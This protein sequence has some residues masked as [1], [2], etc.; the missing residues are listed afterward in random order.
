MRSTLPVNGLTAAFLTTVV[1]LGLAPEASA[2]PRF[3]AFGDGSVW[4]TDVRSAPLNP[5]SAALVTN[6]VGQ[7]AENYG[8]AAFNV[9][10]YGTSIYTVPA[11]QAVVDVAW[12]D[13]QR[14][15]RAPAGLLGEGGQ[16]TAVPIP[17]DAVPAAG[18]DGQLTV[19]SPS[20][21]TLWE[22]WKAKRVNGQWQA[23]WGGRL[24]DVSTSGGY[25]S[26]WWGASASGL[27]VSG[28]SVL[29]QDAQAG[30]VDH[31]LSLQLPEVQEKS[32]YSWP[33]QRS[34][35]DDLSAD[36][37]PEGLRF[38]LDPTVNVE[39]LPLTP[40]AKMVARSAQTYGFIVTDRAGAVAVV[41]ESPSA[42]IAATGVNP[43]TALMRG[44]KS[45][46][47]FKNFPWDKMQALP[48]DHG[49]PSVVPP[50]VPAPV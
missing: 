33:A 8:T 31:A 49:E 41:A 24:D 12:I 50:A 46:E 16:F 48:V 38:R 5:N 9:N 21:D 28:G 14:K 1:T 29:V 30:V 18:T 45:Y 47:I 37:I 19:H 23:C 13:C 43:W 20:S 6:L 4:K 10:T 27:A 44:K 26:G 11:D 39:A 40:I 32:V 34:D 36:A 2:A 22:F 15:G 25:F 35:G 3:E 42:A 7:V 17:S